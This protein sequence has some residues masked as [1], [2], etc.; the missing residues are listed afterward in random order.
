VELGAAFVEFDVWPTPSGQLVVSHDRPG[1]QHRYRWPR[2]LMRSHAGA[3]PVEPFLRLVAESGVLL[4]LD[5]KGQGHEHRVIDLLS[6]FGLLGRTIVSSTE[7]S[8]MVALRRASPRIR[9]GLSVPSHPESLRR[10]SRSIPEMGQIP[11]RTPRSGR[12]EAARTWLLEHLR[13]LL[14]G[15]CSDALMVDHPLASHEVVRGLRAEGAG[16][17][18]WTARD[19][20]TFERLALLGADAIATDD[21]ERQLGRGLP[22]AAVAGYPQRRW[23]TSHP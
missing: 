7:P 3:P 19:V 20:A 16:V 1:M 13:A 6:E 5:W 17:F 8:A 12:I 2:E 15:T 21:I 14:A 18:L 9:T 23:S 11:A 22:A 10:L 4:N